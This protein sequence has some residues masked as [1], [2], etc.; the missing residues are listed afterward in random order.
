MEPAPSASIPFAVFLYHERITLRAVL[1]AL[2][3]VLG[4]ALLFVGR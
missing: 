1:G 4:V 2:L 3:A